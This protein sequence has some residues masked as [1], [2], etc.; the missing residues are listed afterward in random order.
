MK[1]DMDQ[2]VCWCQAKQ[3]E[4]ID[5]NTKLRHFAAGESVPNAYGEN[6]SPGPTYLGAW[7]HSTTIGI[8]PLTY[9]IKPSA[10]KFWH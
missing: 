2:R 10:G 4:G 3:K 5:H 8:G 9:T 7:G 1:P 6:F